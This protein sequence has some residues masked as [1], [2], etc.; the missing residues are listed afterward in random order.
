MR[1]ILI[2]IRINIRLMLAKPLINNGSLLV[3]GKAGKPEDEERRPHR[4]VRYAI[5]K[6]YLS[7][8]TDV[9]PKN[10][11]DDARSICNRGAHVPKSYKP[12]T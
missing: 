8:W 7:D 12:G 10:P 3:P 4:R 2:G 5:G 1:N 11:G 9:M 6:A